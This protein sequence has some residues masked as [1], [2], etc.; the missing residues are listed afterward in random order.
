[1][2]KNKHMTV[3]GEIK[4]RGQIKWTAMMLTEHVQL[5]KDLKKEDRYHTK[6]TLDDFDLENLYEEIRIAYMRPCEIELRLWQNGDLTLTGL[7][8]AIDLN[9]KTICL[10]HSE[11]T[12]TILFTDIIGAKT[13]E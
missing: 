2:K 11:R 8:T 12:E 10:E 13:M 4:D 3:K 9:K 5:L 1:M 6:P 7:I